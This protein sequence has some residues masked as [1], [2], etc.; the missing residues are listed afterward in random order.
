MA[1]V[2]ATSTS[3]APLHR[4]GLQQI[5]F[6][7]AAVEVHAVG[8]AAQCWVG[9]EGLEGE[10]HA[11]R[12]AGPASSRRGSC[13]AT[14]SPRGSFIVDQVSSSMLHCRAALVLVDLAVFGLVPVPEPASGPG[15]RGSL[16]LVDENPTAGAHG[17][18]VDAH[19]G[20]PLLAAVPYPTMS[21]LS[22]D[23]DEV[24]SAVGPCRG[25]RAQRGQPD[26]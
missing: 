18:H 3:A 22:F 20:L 5:R 13:A 25:P 15:S 10:P 9:S 21:D 17:D 14:G 8:P 7:I 11:G 23:T 1:P 19:D 26:L 2:S 24:S 12:A 4:S 16:I 6:P